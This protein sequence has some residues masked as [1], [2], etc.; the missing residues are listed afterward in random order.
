MKLFM[1]WDMEGVSGL[2]RREEAWFWEPGVSRE[3]AEGGRQLLIADINSAVRAALEAGADEVVVTDT[4]HGGGNITLPEMLDDPRVRY[5][6]RSRG[7]QGEVYRWLPGLDRSVDGFL[8]PGHHSKAGTPGGFLPH[9]SN[10][11]W[12]DVTLNG[13]S[14]GEMGIEACYAAHW[15]IPTILAQGDEHGCAEAREYFPGITTAA[16]KRAVDRDRCVG[17]SAE[18]GR[19]L[20]AAKVREAVERLRRKEVKPVL[21][22][23]PMTVR[24]RMTSPEAAAKAATRSA[25]RRV[26]DLTVEGVVGR[27]CDVLAWIQD[28]G[29]QMT[30]RAPR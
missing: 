20:T 16:V 13:R 2:L 30:P 15:G 11:H 19:V 27:H 26:D 24:I 29:I 7:Y 12:A 14:V 1:L 17:M 3:T 18:E 25:V 10:E 6:L 5:N 21:P 9:T 4:H 22:A 28:D 8:V 23:L